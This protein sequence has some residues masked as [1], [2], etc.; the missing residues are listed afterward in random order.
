MSDAESQE[1]G[2]S[3]QN[4]CPVN[5]ENATEHAKTRNES[6]IEHNKKPYGQGD[7]ISITE[8]DGESPRKKSP[9]D[10][11]EKRKTP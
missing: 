6:A 8:G 10:S 11:E 1:K 4:K 2:S 7:I 3:S 5:S 9:C